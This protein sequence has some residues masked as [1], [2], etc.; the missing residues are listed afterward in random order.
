MKLFRTLSLLLLSSMIVFTGC[1]TKQQ[2]SAVKG[3]P[4]L[5]NA[6]VIIYKTKADFSMHVPVTLSDDKQ[7]LTSYPAPSDIY[8]GGDLAYPVTLA[9]GYLL[10]KRGIDGNVAFTRWTYYEYSRLAKTPAPGEIMKMIL[11]N[12]PLIEMYDCGKVNDFNNLEEDLNKIIKSEK[13][14]KFKRIK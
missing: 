1:K 2:V 10:D 12:D 11:E 8:Y 13:L 3:K 14:N 9:N 5:A 4:I 6:P 7:S